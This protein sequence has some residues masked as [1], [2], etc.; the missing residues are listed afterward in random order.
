LKPFDDELLVSPG[1]I[2]KRHHT[3]NYTRPDCYF[4]GK[5]LGEEKLVNIDTPPPGFR[6]LL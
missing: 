6:M 5:S 4:L 2:V 1:F 3:A